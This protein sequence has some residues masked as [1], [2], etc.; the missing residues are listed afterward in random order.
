MENKNKVNKK[1]EL[2]TLEVILMCGYIYT[3]YFIPIFFL[4]VAK[5]YLIVN[6]MQNN[7]LVQIIFLIIIFSY[8]YIIFYRK[9]LIKKSNLP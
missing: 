3:K 1:E 7:Y 8:Y 6:E 2:R 4:I 5:Y 9:D